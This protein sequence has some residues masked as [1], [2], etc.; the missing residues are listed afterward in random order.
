MC[1]RC[2]GPCY[3]C[4]KN[5]NQS[6]LSCRSGYYWIDSETNCHNVAYQ[7]PNGYYKQ[8]LP[9]R[10]CQKCPQFCASCTGPADTSC[11]ACLPSAYFIPSQSRCV[12]ICPQSMYS[13]DFP[14][15]K[16][17]AH[18]YTDC[19]TCT[20]PTNKDCQLCKEDKFWFSSETNCVTSCPANHFYPQLS[21]FKSCQSCHHT[22]LRCNGPEKDKCLEC[23]HGQ[24]LKLTLPNQHGLCVPDCGL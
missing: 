17:C 8:E 9:F 20:G 15:P 3:R 4:T 21:P 7:C 16:I 2:Y 10:S 11:T 18:C 23:P 19:L 6:C 5:D 12:G 24:F 13:R 1:R 14:L 22:C